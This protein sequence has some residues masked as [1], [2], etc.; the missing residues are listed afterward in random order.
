MFYCQ[1]LSL[2]VNPCLHLFLYGSSS[3][4]DNDWRY[5]RYHE[6][7]GRKS[8]FFIWCLKACINF[9]G[10]KV[11]WW[12]RLEKFWK[13]SKN[14][15]KIPVKNSIFRNITS[16][17]NFSKISLYKKANSSRKFSQTYSEICISVCDAID[18]KQSVEG[19]LKV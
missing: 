13:G 12:N 10:T 8:A 11:T 1:D 15:R 18:L 16:C 2:N 5:Q 3:L 7:L 9:I 14:D 19:T 6:L 4:F 17:N